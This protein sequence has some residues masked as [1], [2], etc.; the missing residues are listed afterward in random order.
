MHFPYHF[1]LFYFAY[2]VCLFSTFS[3]LE[4]YYQ[5]VPKTETPLKYYNLAC[6]KKI[7]DSSYTNIYTLNYKLSKEKIAYNS[8]ISTQ[9]FY[10]F[11][12]IYRID[13]YEF[14]IVITEVNKVCDPKTSFFPTAYNVTNIF[15]APIS[16]LN[17]SA[18][19]SN[20]HEDCCS[21]YSRDLISRLEGPKQIILNMNLIFLL[22]RNNAQENIYPE[23]NLFGKMS[24]YKNSED[25]KYFVNRNLSNKLDPKNNR[26]IPKDLFRKCISGIMT[27]ISFSDQPNTAQLLILSRRINAYLGPQTENFGANFE[28]GVNGYMQHELIFYDSKAVR[29]RSYGSHRGPVPL[30]IKQPR[31][32]LPFRSL[33]INTSYQKNECALEN[34]FNKYIFD[35]IV[36]QQSYV[37][38]I[39]SRADELTGGLRMHWNELPLYFVYSQFIN[40]FNQKRNK[41]NLSSIKFLEWDFSSYCPTEESCTYQIER[42]LKPI[43]MEQGFTEFKSSSTSNSYIFEG[44]QA[45]SFRLSGY[46]STDRTNYLEQTIYEIIIQFFLRGYEK[47]N[48]ILA[49]EQVR[50]HWKNLGMQQAELML[51]SSIKHVFPK[52]ITQVI[53]NF[54]VNFQRYYSALWINP[55]R[56]EVFNMLNRDS[57]DFDASKDVPS[58]SN[59]THIASPEFLFSIFPTPNSLLY[60]LVYISQLFNYLFACMILNE[61]FVYN[62]LIE[63]QHVF[64]KYYREYSYLI[65]AVFLETAFAL[66]YWKDDFS[67]FQH[68]FH[69][70]LNYWLQF[71][72]YFSDTWHNFIIFYIFVSLVYV[73]IFGSFSPIFISLW[74]AAFLYGASYLQGLSFANIWL[75]RI[76]K[77]CLTRI[78]NMCLT[79][80]LKMWETLKLVALIIFD[81]C[82]KIMQTH[83]GFRDISSR[84]TL[85][86]T[87]LV[88]LITALEMFR[89]FILHPF[90]SIIVSVLFIDYYKT[91]GFHFA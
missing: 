65:Y 40:S 90:V 88:V 67:T 38:H 1:S 17:T 19:L 62:F 66:L 16:P 29:F 91:H 44:I 59:S 74:G 32:Y 73:I 8:E 68:P 3:C 36:N 7:T 72:K 11:L 30:L 14:A 28:G 77:M 13:R 26:N 89:E 31:T 53:W 86:S 42:V 64:N 49:V 57:H 81:T 12:G 70:Q 58:I 52:T 82:V 34:H 22:P 15:F 6:Y 33:N 5:L 80:I 85:F 55:L 69:Y 56:L 27:C 60:T 47:N 75:P 84:R 51:H 35:N 4:Y 20:K 18:D 2:I 21:A 45:G 48:H 46:D 25:E 83:F 87:I 10:G 54:Y 61:K 43:Y 78:L 71:I 37:L 41:S 63:E 39:T 79:R 24:F 50:S 76:I 9:K 23:L